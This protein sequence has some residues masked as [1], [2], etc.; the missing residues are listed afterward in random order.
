MYL[1]VSLVLP[2]SPAGLCVSC[3]EWLELRTLNRVDAA[4]LWLQNCG[5]SS[6]RLHTTI[7]GSTCECRQVYRSSH[8]MIIV[9]KAGSALDSRS[10]GKTGTRKSLVQPTQASRLANST[11]SQLDDSLCIK[12]SRAQSQL[13]GSN[14]DS[15]ATPFR[16]PLAVSRY[17]SEMAGQTCL[18]CAIDTLDIGA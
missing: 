9:A 13:E 8:S 12:P 6:P 15:A 3:F 17:A 10:S 18:D 14:G 16:S 11:R 7:A 1:S 5:Y 4:R 2:L